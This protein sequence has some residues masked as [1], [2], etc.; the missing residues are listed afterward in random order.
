MEKELETACK[1]FL[2]AFARLVAAS[3]CAGLT[4]GETLSALDWQTLVSTAGQRTAAVPS[5]LS[6]VAAG[7]PAGVGGN[8]ATPTTGSGSLPADHY[9]HLRNQPTSNS[10]AIGAECMKCN[11]KTP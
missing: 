11:L 10:R 9:P 3:T 4:V 6:Q 5:S 2:L 1:A 8:P 7:A